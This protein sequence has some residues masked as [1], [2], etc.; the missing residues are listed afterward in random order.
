VVCQ[1]RVHQGLNARVPLPTT[2]VVSPQVAGVDAHQAAGQPLWRLFT[3]PF[4]DDSPA[5][6]AAVEVAARG[7]EF[8]LRCCRV[9]DAPEQGTFSLQF[10]SA[11]LDSCCKPCAA[12][13]SYS[14]TPNQL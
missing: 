14:R 8:I 13:Q 4:A 11:A 7:D 5:W 3:R 1:M 9:A 2:I 12:C 6:E 10:R